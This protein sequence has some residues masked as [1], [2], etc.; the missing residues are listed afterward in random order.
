MGLNADL[1]HS[2]FSLVVDREPQLTARFYE[3]LF[4]RHPDARPLFHRHDPQ[5]QQKMLQEALVAVLDH[6]DDA[7]WLTDTLGA[8]GAKHVEYGVTEPM[9]DWVGECLLA[10]LEEVAADDWSPE[11]ADAW[12]DAYGAIRELMLAGAGEPAPRRVSFWKRLWPFG[13]GS[14]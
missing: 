3:H 12:G 6:L 1:L 13:R 10:T 5:Q 11:L 9:Y 8:L 4:E 7:P 2:S 14:A